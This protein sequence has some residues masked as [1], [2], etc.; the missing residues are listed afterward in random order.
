MNQNILY[1]ARRWPTMLFLGVAGVLL[2]GCGGRVANPFGSSAPPNAVRP[3]VAGDSFTYSVSEV[4]TLGNGTVQTLTGTET[5]VFTAD[6]YGGA[7]TLR[8]TDTVSVAG[9]TIP[10]DIK[11]FQTN[12]SGASTGSPVAQSEE[13]TLN[14]GTLES[15]VTGK[16]IS[17]LTILYNSNLDGL[18][19]LADGTTITYVWGVTGVQSVQAGNGT[20]YNCWT[21]SLTLTWSDGLNQ[22]ES[23][24]YSPVLGAPVQTQITNT[25]NNG[26][27]YTYTSTLSSATLGGG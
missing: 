10:A 15:I 24:S 27:T 7:N 8:D 26:S 25:A 3:N 16:L 23:I 1:F 5:N 18:E 4:Q 13:G 2:A 19:T 6:T 21:I 22:I 12:S 14:T 17:P 11:E 20:T 9:I